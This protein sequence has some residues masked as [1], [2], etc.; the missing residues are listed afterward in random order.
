M[1]TLTM[2]QIDLVSGGLNAKEALGT[3]GAVIGLYYGAGI[4]LS[5]GIPGMAIALVLGIN[6]GTGL[7][8]PGVLSTTLLV[9]TGFI[10]TCS[11]VGATIGGLA[12]L[13]GGAVTDA[14][15]TA[16]H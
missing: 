15:I 8:I 5:I 11:A 13:M 2:E 3:A 9:G 6:G 4:G 16:A 14:I 12:G 10:V 1:Q 7:L